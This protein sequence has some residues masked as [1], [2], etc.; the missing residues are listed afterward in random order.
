MDKEYALSLVL[1]LNRHIERF[2]RAIENERRKDQTDVEAFLEKYDARK[3]FKIGLIDKIY[4]NS[5]M[6]DVEMLSKT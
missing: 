2:F 5:R 3:K 4:L 6:R 1:E